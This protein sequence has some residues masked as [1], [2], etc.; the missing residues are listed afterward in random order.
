MIKTTEDVN[1]ILKD[2]LT[3]IIFNKYDQDSYDKIST[4]FEKVAKEIEPQTLEL[5]DIKFIKPALK[6]EYEIQGKH[7]TM[8]IDIKRK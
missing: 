5:Q 6:L 4:I 7:F 3:D 8:V 2:K 1:D